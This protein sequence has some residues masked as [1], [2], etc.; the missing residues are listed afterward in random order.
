[1]ARVIDDGSAVVDDNVHAVF[2]SVGAILAGYQAERQVVLTR[3]R[4][5]LRRSVEE[6]VGQERASAF[7]G[8]EELS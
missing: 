2:G 7:D 1:V 3:G 8:G 5:L 4:E 6:S